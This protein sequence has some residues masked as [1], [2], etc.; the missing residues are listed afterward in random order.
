MAGAALGTA[1]E[2]L[3]NHGVSDEDVAYYGN[4]LKKDG[5]VLVTVHPHGE[6]SQQSIQQI[7]HAHGGHNAAQPRTA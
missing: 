2:A 7:L 3:K 1:N 6:A 5:G 4:T